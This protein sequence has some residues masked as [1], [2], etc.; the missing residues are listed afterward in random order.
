MLHRSSSSRRRRASRSVANSPQE[1]SG[2]PLAPQV[3]GRRASVASTEAS[4]VLAQTFGGL[5]RERSPRGSIVPNISLDL[6]GDVPG[7]VS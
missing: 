7:E 4:D 1:H 3:R 5:E 2:M 6:E